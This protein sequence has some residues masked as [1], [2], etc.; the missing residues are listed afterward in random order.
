MEFKYRAAQDRRT[1]SPQP[2]PLSTGTY[3]SDRPLRGC[4]F[5]SGGYPGN[6]PAP[7]VF[8][9]PVP[10][11]AG[12]AFRRELEK[13]QIRREIL[14]REMTRRREL[15]EEV[16]REIALERVLGIPFRERAWVSL[17]QDQGMNN[18]VN[19]NIFGGS[20]PSL[21]PQ[22][23]ISR[24]QTNKDKVIILFS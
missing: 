4:E 12:E 19:N 17:N 5:S 11:N 16:R 22:I 10:V 9:T 20:Q 24:Q 23:D 3:V 2:Y 8:R 18:P 13:K 15:E 21:S 14:A 6:V 7:R 1:S